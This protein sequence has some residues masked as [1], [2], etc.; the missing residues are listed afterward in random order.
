[1]NH[2]L[3]KRLLRGNFKQIISYHPIHYSSVKNAINENYRCGDENGLQRHFKNNQGQ[4]MSALCVA[5]VNMVFGDY[6][7]LA[8]GHSILQ[9]H[10]LG[11][12]LPSF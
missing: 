12:A 11:P 10:Q 2:I 3:T 7:P 5:A 6:K 9:K 1:M 4:N 8:T